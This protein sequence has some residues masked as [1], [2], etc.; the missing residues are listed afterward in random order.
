QKMCPGQPWQTGEAW[1]AWSAEECQFDVHGWRAEC[2]PPLPAT[3][4]WH[5]NASPWL[6]RLPE[7]ISCLPLTETGPVIPSDR[8]LIPPSRPCWL[9]VR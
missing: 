4:G 3:P 8:H 1:F 6:R 2:L 9:F 7:T 5:L